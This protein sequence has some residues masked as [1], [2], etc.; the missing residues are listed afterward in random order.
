[1]KMHIR[2]KISSKKFVKIWILLLK[3]GLRMIL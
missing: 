2:K 3:E 1:M